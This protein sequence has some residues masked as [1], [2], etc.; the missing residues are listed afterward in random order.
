MKPLYPY[1]KLSLEARDLWAELASQGAMTTATVEARWGTV[2]KR[3]K[4][5]QKVDRESKSWALAPEEESAQNYS[6][7]RQSVT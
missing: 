4:P 1:T 5:D 6:A 3:H 7:A 2:A